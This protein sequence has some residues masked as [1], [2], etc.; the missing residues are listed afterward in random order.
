MAVQDHPFNRAFHWPDRPT[1]GLRR[2][3]AEQV[4]QYN[5]QGFCLLTGATPPDTVAELIAA[6]DPIE[7][8]VG[9]Y[10]IVLEDRTAFTYEADAMTFANDLVLAS[11]QVRAFCASPLFQDV[12]HDLLGD[13]VRLYWN[14]AVYKKPDKGRTFPWHQDNGYTYCEPQA[15]L[16]CW[17]ALTDA[18]VDNG[19]PWVIPG[20][21]RR[22]RAVPAAAG[23]M[24]IFSSLTPHKTGANVT[25]GVRKALILQYAADG[26]CRIDT[27][28]RT[29]PQD[30]LERN[31]PILRGGAPVAAR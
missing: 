20:L 4:A 19:C 30:D 31:F 3:T 17:L 7:A 21:H 1:T 2:L 11:P 14:Q 25:D 8:Q 15:Y 5:E 12:T 27:D 24:V 13:D 18:T 28:G 16:T 26:A 23:D 6:I 29:V 22:G 10:T 9:D